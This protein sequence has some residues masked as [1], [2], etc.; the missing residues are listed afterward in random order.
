MGINPHILVIPYPAQGHVIP[1][2]E[3]SR[4]LTKHGFKITF[5]NT[6]FNHKRVVDAFPNKV[7]GEGRPIHLVSI[8]DGMEL[9]EDRNDLGKLTDGIS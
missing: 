6:D 9:G 1:L 4:S 2:M 7:D 8:P 3:L 5:V